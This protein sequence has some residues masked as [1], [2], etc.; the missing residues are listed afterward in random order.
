MIFIDANIF[1]YAAGNESPQKAP[2]QK[3]LKEVVLSGKKACT[4]AE[5]LQ[6]ILHRYIAIDARKVGFAIFDQI[7]SLSIPILAIEAK[8]LERA[9][10]ILEEHPKISSRDA[11]HLGV[12]QSHGISRIATYDKGFKKVDWVEVISLG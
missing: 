1:M 3:F 5:V 4:N 6:E 7:L 9:R 8:D 2:C 10:L 12:M 11:V